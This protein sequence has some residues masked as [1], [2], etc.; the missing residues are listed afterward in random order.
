MVS[1]SIGGCG[2]A[3]IIS[4]SAP[5]AVREQLPDFFSE[6]RFIYLVLL[7]NFSF[8]SERAA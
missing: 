1:R 7:Q 2:D 3:L 6:L 5:K 8:R 4:Q